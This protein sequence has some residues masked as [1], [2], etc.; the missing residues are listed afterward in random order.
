MPNR[1]APNK[2]G[3]HQK[4]CPDLWLYLRGGV[5]LPNGLADPSAGAGGCSRSPSPTCGSAGS[6]DDSSTRSGQ[7]WHRTPHA[8]AA[9]WQHIFSA[10]CTDR[11]RHRLLRGRFHSRCPPK[12]VHGRPG[13]ER[14]G[15]ERWPR[16]TGPCPSPA[17]GRTQSTLAHRTGPGIASFLRARS[18]R[19]HSWR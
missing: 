7:P 6:L 18:G 1:A 19:H 11:R 15:Q 16:Q 10:F 13:H 14:S 3:P 4:C 2:G 12:I 17:R 5:C 9:P 8:N